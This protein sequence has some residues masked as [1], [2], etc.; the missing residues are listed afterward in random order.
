MAEEEDELPLD[1]E[2]VAEDE[3]EDVLFRRFSFLWP[4]L[5]SAVAVCFA[6]IISPTFLLSCFVRDDLCTYV[7][8]PVHS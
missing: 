6:S 3:V 4:L 7:R 8:F 5:N 1:E 2:D